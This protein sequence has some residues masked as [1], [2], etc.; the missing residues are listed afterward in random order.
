MDSGATDVA[1]HAT[2]VAEH[3]GGEILVN[4]ICKWNLQL[5]EE[6]L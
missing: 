5:I 3:A 1:E 6:C 4:C 2:D